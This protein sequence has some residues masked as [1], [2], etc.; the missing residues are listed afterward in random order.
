[1]SFASNFLLA[2]RQLAHS[3]CQTTHHHPTS[4]RFLSTTMEYAS[5]DTWSA[6]Q[7]SKFIN[8]RTRPAVEL[9]NRVSVHNPKTVVDLGCGPGNSTAVLAERYPHANV[10]G[11]DSSADMIQKAKSTLPGVSFEVEDLQSFKPDEPIDVL[12]SNA[13]FQWLPS[14]R[15]IQ[16]ITQLLEHLSVG[17]T[18]AFQIPFNMSEPSHVTMR[19]TA[20]APGTPWVDTLRQVNPVRE[21]FPTPNDLYDGLKAH[22]SELD[23]WTTTYIHVMENHEAIIEWVKGTGLRP[24]IDPLSEAERRGFVEYYLQ[25]LR[26]VYPVQKDG[27]VLLPYPRLFVVAT[28]G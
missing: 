15:R 21:E 12:F 24:F 22:C 27:K 7:Y 10:S 16:I 23:I 25:R 5:K 28:K 1:M 2:R 8:E 17:G 9:L 26:E 4:K 13:V 20:F 11:I 6:N 3:F 14:G 19:E 18:L